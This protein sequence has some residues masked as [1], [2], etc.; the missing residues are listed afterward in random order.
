MSEYHVAT[1][2]KPDE[3]ANVLMR[4]L[5]E[6]G[7]KS[8]NSHNFPF[9]CQIRKTLDSQNKLTGSGIRSGKKKNIQN[10]RI[11]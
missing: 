2:D 10:Y 9:I 4:A 1:T 11:N 5:G 6:K 8:T 7:R 3:L